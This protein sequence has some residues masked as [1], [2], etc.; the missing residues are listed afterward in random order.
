MRD[1]PTR[2]DPLIKFTYSMGSENYMGFTNNGIRN[3]QGSKDYK[4]M[5]EKAGIKWKKWKISDMGNVKCI[6]GYICNLKSV[7]CFMS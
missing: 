2:W 1:P 4:T 6:G 3:Y 5:E 7:M